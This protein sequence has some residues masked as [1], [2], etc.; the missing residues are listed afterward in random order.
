MLL[1]HPR[2]EPTL[3][4]VCFVCAGNICRSPMAETAFEGMLR[5]SGTEDRIGVLSA[6]INRWH[7]GHSADR[8]ALAALKAR[9][10]DASNHRA[11]RFDPEWFEHLD[12]VVPLDRSQHQRLTQL[13]RSNSDREKIHQLLAFEPSLAP[14][15]D[16]PDPYFADDEA[17]ES[18]LTM[19][20][21]ACA[22]LF[23]SILSGITPP[24][25][26]QRT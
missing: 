1:R 18:V 23:D 20:E 6:G 3:F 10:Y 7:L 2:D 22:A 24:A 26:P 21:K 4:R 5:A 15:V 9:G 19:I 17:F 14:I 8:R 16:V 11:R 25:A 12:L 13:A